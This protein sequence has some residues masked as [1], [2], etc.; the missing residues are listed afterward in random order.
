MRQGLYYCFQDQDV[1]ASKNVLFHRQSEP[2]LPQSMKDTLPYLLGAVNEDHLLNLQELAKAKRHFIS[3]QKEYQDHEALKGTSTGKGLAL[4]AEARSL[5]MIPMNQEVESIEDAHKVLG[6]IIGKD[7]SSA[8]FN[9]IQDSGK[10]YLTLQNELYELENE[11]QHVEERIN[12]AKHFASGATGFQGEAEEQM[13][14]L[15]SIGLFKGRKKLDLCPV[16]HSKSD[17][18]KIEKDITQSVDRLRKELE[19]VTR[20]QPKINE[21]MSKLETQRES[22]ATKFR[23][24][25]REIEG[26]LATQ[27]A[28]RTYHDRNLRVG[29]TLGRVS[30]WLDSVSI[31]SEDKGLQKQIDKWEKEVKRLE[32]LVDAKE[33]EER[34][35]SIINRI[36]DQM[37]K[38]STLLKLEHSGNPVRFDLKDLTVVIDMEDRPVPLKR[39]GSGENHVGYHL[40]ALTALH[41]HFIKNNRPV[42]RFLVLDQPSQVYYPPDKYD[43]KGSLALVKDADKE[44][45]ERM[46]KFIFNFVES[47]KGKFQ[48]ILLDHA[49]PDDKE[50]RSYIVEEWR[51]GKALI[52]S[53]W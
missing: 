46:Y 15:Q 16:C 48:V 47:Q 29:M 34:L 27:A 23:K 33:V 22:H 39:I 8:E 9:K 53:D 11:L 36:S 7:H 28:M 10:D 24:K 14:R 18:E 17:A 37:T 50:F 45:L 4:V 20:E 19:T 32:K 30:L 42:P 43:D 35:N 3:L 26:I 6:R 44:A 1:I 31:T 52:P 25:Q 51:D 49:N 2:F 12:T 13:L 21:Y 5:G 41:G 40:L 38:E